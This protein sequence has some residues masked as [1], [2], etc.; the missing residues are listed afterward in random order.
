[1]VVS[2]YPEKC[3]CTATALANSRL[4]HIP[5]PLLQHISFVMFHYF[6]SNAL[7]CPL[8]CVCVCEHRNQTIIM[9]ALLI[10][11][12]SALRELT[13]PLR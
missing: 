2:Y 9:F 3:F 10:G 4:L 12:F 11:F 7:K 8:L 5:L 6:A 13:Q 1:M